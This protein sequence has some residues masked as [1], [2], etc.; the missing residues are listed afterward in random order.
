MDRNE[1]D[2]EP[3]PEVRLY[4]VSAVAKRCAVSEAMVHKLIREDRIRSVQIGRSRRIPS[5][6]V[7]RLIEHGTSVS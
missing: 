1:H 4:S 2:I 5:D 3:S 6:E 7:D